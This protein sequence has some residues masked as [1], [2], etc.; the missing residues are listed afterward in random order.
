MRYAELYGVRDPSYFR[1]LR[2]L[3]IEASQRLRRGQLDFKKTLTEKSCLNERGES[4][5]KFTTY[6]IFFDLAAWL[7]PG[8]SPLSS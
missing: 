3:V 8:A 2:R 7:R 1:E 6:G 4:S 5:A